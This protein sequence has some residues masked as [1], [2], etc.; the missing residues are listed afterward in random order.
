[1]L[2]SPLKFGDKLVCEDICRALKDGCS[3]SCIHSLIR[4]N[5]KEM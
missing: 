2:E 3:P 5:R 4:Q 1:M